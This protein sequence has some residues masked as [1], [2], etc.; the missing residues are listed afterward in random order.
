MAV[1][2]EMPTGMSTIHGPYI[3]DRGVW[4]SAT[5]AEAA[6]A[7]AQAIAVLDRLVARQALLIV[8]RDRAHCLAHC[9]E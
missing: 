3:L 1:W 7:C 4:R 5:N 9:K 8:L 2:C 6:A